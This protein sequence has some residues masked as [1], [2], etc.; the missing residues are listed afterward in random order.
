MRERTPIIDFHS[1]ILPGADHG[2]TSVQTSLTQLKM[3]AQSGTEEI[4]ATSHYYPHL[5]TVSSYIN[6]RNKCFENLAKAA[7]SSPFGLK[8]M[9]GAEVLVCE[10]LEQ[11]KGLE[12]LC[13]K[14][15]KT[16]LLEMPFMP[17][18][19][20]LTQTV[21]NISK[22]GFCVV[23]AHIDRYDFDDVC[24]L[25]DGT[26][27]KA[28]INTSALKSAKVKKRYIPMIKDGAVVAL[29]S[30]LH[31]DKNGSYR[32]FKKVCE[33]LGDDTDIIMQ[34]TIQYIDNAEKFSI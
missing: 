8:I 31:G 15:T 28:Q 24:E 25:M 10:K 13:I 5:H 22:L 17:F 3:I 11:M 9:L 33:L 27:I 19:E 26:N 2:S 12:E 21:V 7:S 14:G 6:R 18:R 30:D 4:V 16:I 23:L 29:G 34:R 32:H 20:E 1:H